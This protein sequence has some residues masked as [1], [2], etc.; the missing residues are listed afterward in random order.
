MSAIILP[1]QAFGNTTQ[2]SREKNI[3]KLW[4]ASLFLA[5]SY[6]HTLHIKK[7]DMIVFQQPGEMICE[8]YIKDVEWSGG[9]LC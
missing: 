6:C 8:Q 2:R 5:S 7:N 9:D 1:N 4:H 3:G